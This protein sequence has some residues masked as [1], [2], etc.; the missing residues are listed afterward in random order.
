MPKLNALDAFIRSMVCPLKSPVGRPAEKCNN[1][2]SVIHSFGHKLSVAKRV[3]D[4]YD[5]GAN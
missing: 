1:S 5:I 2:G 4:T 3:I